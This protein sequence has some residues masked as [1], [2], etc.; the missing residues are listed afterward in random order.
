M[1]FRK[2]ELERVLD[3]VEHGG[4]IFLDFIFPIKSVVLSVFH[5]DLFL[6]EILGSSLLQVNN[7]EKILVVKY[8]IKQFIDDRL[9]YTVVVI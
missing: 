7:F 1:L 3:G 4:Q 6:D 2:S 8:L 5:D 9:F